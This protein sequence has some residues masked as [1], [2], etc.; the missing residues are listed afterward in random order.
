MQHHLSIHLD[1]VYYYNRPYHTPPFATMMFFVFCVVPDYSRVSSL[2]ISADSI[3][4]LDRMEDNLLRDEPVHI[5]DRLVRC[6]RQ[7]RDTT[8]LLISRFADS[9]LRERRRQPHRHHQRKVAVHLR[10][11]RAVEDKLTYRAEG[12]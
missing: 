8:Q 10:G 9:E 2:V 11:R 6:A 4:A 12:D 1:L 5:P 3:R 7:R